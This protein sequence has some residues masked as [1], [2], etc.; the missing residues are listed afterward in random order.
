MMKILKAMQHTSS[1]D[2]EDTDT[3]SSSGGKVAGVPD[4]THTQTHTRVQNLGGCTSAHSQ[5]SRSRKAPA[6][7]KRTAGAARTGNAKAKSRTGKVRIL[8]SPHN[9]ASSISIVRALVIAL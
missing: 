1:G 7:K 3:D 8:R 9:T 5:E 4:A 6:T 2:E